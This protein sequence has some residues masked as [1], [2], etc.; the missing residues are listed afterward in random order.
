MTLEDPRVLWEKHYQR[1]KEAGVKSNHDP[2]LARWLDTLA[3]TSALP[4]LELGCG[5]GADTRWMRAA[6]LRV[7]AGDFCTTA[8]Q[9][10]VAV[11]PD[12]HF[13]CLR[14]QRY[15]GLRFHIVPIAKMEAPRPRRDAS[16]C[17]FPSMKRTL[18]TQ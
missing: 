2:W 3:H 7:I 16:S 18:L 11:T 15:T 8:L 13:I 12:T 17:V 4:V 6:G 1:I 14:T 5:S 9:T 10:A